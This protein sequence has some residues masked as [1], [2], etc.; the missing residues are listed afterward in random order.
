[1]FCMWL[2]R[3]M[4]LHHCCTQGY[5]CRDS[6]GLSQVATSTVLCQ[7][8][9]KCYYL[10]IGLLPRSQYGLLRIKIS[11]SVSKIN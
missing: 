10:G 11:L 7:I 1:M 4:C 9:Q 3:V 6:I 5:H 8:L 2:H